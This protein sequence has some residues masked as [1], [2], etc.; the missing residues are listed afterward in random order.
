MPRY[1]RY[2]IGGERR[3]GRVVDGGLV[4]LSGCPFEAAVAQG[5]Q[6]LLP[7]DRLRLAPPTA[8]SKIICVGRNYRAHAA[9]LGHDVPQEPLLF[10]KPP[11]AL[12]GPGAP[13]V[14]PRGESELV[15]HEGELAVVIGRRA[16][17]VSEADAADHIFGYTTFNDVTAR[18]LQRKD[19]QFTRGKSFDTFGPMGP[20]IDTDFTPADQRVVVRVSGEVRQDGHLG[21]MVFRP[22]FL[23][24]YITR[25]MTLEPGDVIATGTPAGVGPL[26]PGDRVEVRIDGLGALSNPVVEPEG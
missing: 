18:D 17:R 7:W 19:V 24:A 26:V 3:W 22:H 9:E 10:L 16:R 20:W 11:S 5:P 13:I 15:H 6:P 1:A 4:A 21:Q 14:Y 12:V 8:P 25:V 2:T 23:V